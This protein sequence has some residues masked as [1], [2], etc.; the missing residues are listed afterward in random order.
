MCLLY[1]TLLYVSSGSDIRIYIAD[2]SA[3]TLTLH[4]SLT[5]SVH[6]AVQTACTSASCPDISVGV[7]TVVQTPTVPGSNT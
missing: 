7:S 6:T 4:A 2:W 1:M 3:M 5:A